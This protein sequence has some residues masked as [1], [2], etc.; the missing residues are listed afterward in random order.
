MKLKILTILFLAASYSFGQTADEIVKKS[1]DKL[2]GTSSYTELT[3]DIIRPKWSKEMKMKGWT[4]G[5]DH[6]VSVITSPAKEKGTVFLMREKEVWNYLLTIE[7]TVKFPPSMMLQNWMGTDLTNDDLIKQSSLVTDYTKKIIDEEEKEGYPCWKIELAP[8][9]NAA[10]VWGKIIIWID[11]KEYMQMQIDYY[12]EDMFL[13]NQMVGSKVKTFDGKLLPSKL[14]V[15]PVDK[16]GQSTVITYNQ[17]KFDMDI[18][19]EYFTT[20]Y[21]KR[22]H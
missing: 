19:D 1:D 22:I 10:V 20:N 6:S 2:R 8:K 4:R 14:T 13:V 15:T 5:S 17:W 3:I 21:M 18:P 7:R 12:D 16:P 11:K 9:P